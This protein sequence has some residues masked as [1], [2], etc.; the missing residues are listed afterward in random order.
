VPT[1]EAARSKEWVCG[2]SLA[3]IVGSNPAGVWMSVSRECCVL[4]GRV[5]CDGPISRQE[6]SY[7]V[8]CVL[9]VI[10]EPQQIRGLSL[11]GLSSHVK[12]M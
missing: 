7:R 11:R 3:G 6:E 1:L 4:S 10:A 8:W 9:S 5:L 2:R 12:E